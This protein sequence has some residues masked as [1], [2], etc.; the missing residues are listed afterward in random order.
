[1]GRTL[2]ELV[3][4]LKDMIEDMQSDAHNASS[5]S[6]HRYNNLKIEIPESSTARM[7]I[8]KISIGISE[9]TYNIKTLEK[10]SG[11]LGQDEKYINKWLKNSTVVMDLKEAWKSRSKVE[12]NNSGAGGKTNLGG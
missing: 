11:S 5:F 6:R 7:P 8:F 12:I 2:N 9:A 3:R 4:H 1:M 10:I